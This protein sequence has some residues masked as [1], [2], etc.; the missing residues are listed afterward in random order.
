MGTFTVPIQLSGLDG[1]RFIDQ[2]ALVDTGATYK[3]IPASTR[4]ESGIEVRESRSFELAGDR[5][6]EF[7]VGYASI[8][9]EER[10]MIAMA[11]FAGEGAPPLLG[12][13][14]YETA[15]LAVD[16]VHQRLIPVPALLK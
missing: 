14:A 3:S 12:A 15:S 6:V 16:P 2:E 10:E 9:F 4:A 1:Q 7:S 11:V 8:R 5:I 13:T